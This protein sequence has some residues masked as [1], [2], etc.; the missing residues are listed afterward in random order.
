M[1]QYGCQLGET[2]APIDWKIKRERGWIGIIY[3]KCSHKRRLHRRG[4]YEDAHV[5]PSLLV[6]EQ[7]LVRLLNDLTNIFAFVFYCIAFPLFK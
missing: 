6:L 2:G 7:I 5:R 3:E 1:Y 4:M